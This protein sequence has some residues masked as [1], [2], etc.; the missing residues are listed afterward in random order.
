MLPALLQLP[1]ILEI[2]LG[3][4]TNKAF[5]EPL[6]ASLHLFSGRT[7]EKT[8]CQSHLGG[9]TIPSLRRKYQYQSMDETSHTYARFC[10]PGVNN[11]SITALEVTTN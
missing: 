2:F 11:V 9:F 1:K 8:V 4:T 10:H 3:R 7:G 5:P 6:M